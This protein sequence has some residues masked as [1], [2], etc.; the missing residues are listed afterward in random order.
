MPVVE[1]AKIQH[2]HAHF[3]TNS[4]EVAMLAHVLGGPNW[5]F[6]VHGPEEF[7]KPQLIGLPEK[8]RRAHSSSPSVLLAAASC[9]VGSITEY[10]E[11]FIVVRCG[12]EPQYYFADAPDY[13][14]REASSALGGFASKKDSYC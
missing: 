6:T 12:L 13:S 7:D 10:W 3:G 1:V 9:F 4:A 14:L 8:I 2:L 5:S 11:R